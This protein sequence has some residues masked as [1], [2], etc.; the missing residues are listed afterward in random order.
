MKVRDEDEANELLLRLTQMGIRLL[1]F[2][3]KEPTLHEIFVEKVGE[4]S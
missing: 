4:V 2:E 3:I 1:K